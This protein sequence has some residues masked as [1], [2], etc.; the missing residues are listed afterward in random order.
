MWRLACYLRQHGFETSRINSSRVRPTSRKIWSSAA[1]QAR[2][3]AARARHTDNTRRTCPNPA[4]LKGLL[5]S[6]VVG[7]A[8]PAAWA[9]LLTDIHPRAF[10]AIGKFRPMACLTGAC[11]RLARQAGSP[12]ALLCSLPSSSSLPFLQHQLPE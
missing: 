1:F 2:R 6:D 5:P 8:T 7:A 9:E 11:Y 3:S 10:I 4:V 12:T